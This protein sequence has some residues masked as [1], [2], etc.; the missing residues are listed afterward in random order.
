ML[1]AYLGS[2]IFVCCHKSGVIF[3]RANQLQCYNMGL[4]LESLI[5]VYIF[6]TQ[7]L[8]DFVCFVFCIWNLKFSFNKL[9]KISEFTSK[10]NCSWEWDTIWTLGFW[11]G[12]KLINE[13]DLQ[14]ENTEWW[15]GHS[16]TY[17]LEVWHVVFI[18]HLAVSAC[19]WSLRTW[20]SSLE[21]SR[22]H[23]SPWWPPGQSW[24]RAETKMC[25]N[26]EIKCPYWP[27]QQTHWHWDV[28][29]YGSPSKLY[30]LS[31]TSWTL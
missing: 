17:L 21:V 10:L 24:W 16:E 15:G 20:G 1:P 19:W 3:W 30:L 29:L 31:A 23:R 7:R 8:I 25:Q 22:K 12:L 28:K 14:V 26:K 6:N 27:A 18:T 11:F 4:F 13:L 9:N 5:C 2:F